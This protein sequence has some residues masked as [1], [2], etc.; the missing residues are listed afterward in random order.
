MR[1]KRLQRATFPDRAGPEGW[2]RPRGL[3]DRAAR[4]AR[5]EL[6]GQRLAPQAGGAGSP[7]W[8]CRCS[9]RRPRRPCTDLSVSRG[10]AAAIAYARIM[11]TRSKPGEQA[12]TAT[13]DSLETE[14]R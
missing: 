8:I 11:S 10:R 12:R 2:R 5:R 7:A 6:R 3:V 14:R 4:L 13:D 9:A 1:F